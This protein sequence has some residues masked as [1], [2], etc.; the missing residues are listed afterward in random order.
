MIND[1]FLS[2]ILFTLYILQLSFLFVKWQWSFL[3]TIIVL[4]YKI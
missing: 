3:L 4:L 2:L 1:S